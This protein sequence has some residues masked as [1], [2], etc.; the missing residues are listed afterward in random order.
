MNKWYQQTRFSIS[1]LGYT[2]VCVHEEEIQRREKSPVS[3][4]RGKEYRG[5]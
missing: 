5:G 1:R 3:T 4:L 2:E